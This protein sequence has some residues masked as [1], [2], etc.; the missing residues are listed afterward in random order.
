MA[1]KPRGKN[2]LFVRA[3]IHTIIHAIFNGELKLKTS[4]LNPKSI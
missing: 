1:E 2:D 4:Y 3:Y